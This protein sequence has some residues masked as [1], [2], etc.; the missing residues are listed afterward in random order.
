MFLSSV[1]IQDLSAK[2]PQKNILGTCLG[3]QTEIKP[4]IAAPSKDA[5]L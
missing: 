1:Q 3:L 5:L 2:S 4:L